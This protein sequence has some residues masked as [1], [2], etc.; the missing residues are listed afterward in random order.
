MRVKKNLSLVGI[1]PLLLKK[2]SSFNTQVPRS[3]DGCFHENISSMLPYSTCV[4]LLNKTADEQLPLSYFYSLF[5]MSLG[6]ISSYKILIL[7]NAKGSS[8]AL[9]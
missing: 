4:S 7:L 2:W 9:Q 5:L 6:Q 8:V 3:S 1:F